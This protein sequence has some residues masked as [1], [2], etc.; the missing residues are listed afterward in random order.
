MPVKK[1][2]Q[3]FSLISPSC[4]ADGRRLL[5][6]IQYVVNIPNQ[7]TISY[8]CTR[9]LR[10]S[11][12]GIISQLQCLLPTPL[13]GEDLSNMLPPDSQGQSQSLLVLLYDELCKHNTAL[14]SIHALLQTVLG[15]IRGGGPF[16]AKIG[17]T[18]T[19][20]CHNVLPVGWLTLPPFNNS[21]ARTKML[22]AIKLLRHRIQFYS[23]ALQSGVLPST[24]HPLWFSNPADLLSKM[25][26]SFAWEHQLKGEEVSIKTR[27]RS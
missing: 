1:C 6:D 8:P 7:H 18:L 16:S 9:S 10:E 2:I 20:I 3:I 4:N 25:Q 14:I 23:R 21:G 17:T 5:Q 27:V 22:P 11:H 19:A 12:E 13:S 15:Y 24:V 26:Q